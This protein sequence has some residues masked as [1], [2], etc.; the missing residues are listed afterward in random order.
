MA[1]NNL[2]FSLCF[3]LVSEA[4]NAVKQLYRQ[5]NP[6]DF[7]HTIVD[8]GF[9]LREGDKI[10]EDIEE[11]KDDNTILL[12]AL[13]QAYGSEYLRIENKGVSQN[14]TA[15]YEH[16]MPDDSDAMTC[17]DVDEIPIE[18]GWVK[19]LGDVIRADKTMGY[20]APL[21]ID[22]KKALEKSKHVKLEVVKGYNVWRMSGSCNYGLLSVSGLLMN[23]MKGMPIPKITPIYGNIEWALLEG[24]KEHGMWW[25]VL[26]DY[27]QAH[28]NVPLLYREWK[29]DLIFGK[30]KNEK[31]IP[32]EDWLI[33][34][35][36]NKL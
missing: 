1:N 21:L 20:C 13:A 26:K 28:T 32:F 5:N 3:N 17:C 9:P 23:K 19:A 2:V 24:I 8:C 25:G 6:D 33:L 14:W 30:Y 35:R 7:R 18:S 27:T 15:V 31:Q 16:Y 4:E 36:E 11:A 10:P 12:K 22:N 34:K 29:N